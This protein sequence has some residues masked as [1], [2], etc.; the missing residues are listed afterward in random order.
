MSGNQVLRFSL[1]RQA[2]DSTGGIAV[3]R[4]TANGLCLFKQFHEARMRREQLRFPSR[5]G[6][7]PPMMLFPRTGRPVTAQF[8]SCSLVSSPLEWGHRACSI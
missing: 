1:T 2:I 5:Q 7:L 6:K 4:R 8:F 3:L